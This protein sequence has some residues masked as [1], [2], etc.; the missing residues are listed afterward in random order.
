[1]IVTPESNHQNRM[2]AL[3]ATGLLAVASAIAGWFYHPLLLLAGLCPFVYWSFRRHCLQ[4]MAVMKQPFPE[5]WE[6]ILRAHVTFFSAL[7]AAE[8]ERFRQIVKVFLSEV[9]ITGI[10]TEVDDTVRVLVAASAVIPIFGFHD[11]EYHRLGEVLIYPASFGKQYE[12]K[13]Q[14]D[15]NILGMVGLK[16]LS[17]VMILS[18]PALLAGFDNPT[19]KENV[20]VHEFAHLVEQEEIEHGIPPEVPW[21]AVRQWLQYVAKEL[22]HPPGAQSHVNTYA[23]TNEHEMFAVLAE[24]FFKSPQVLE[25]KDPKLYKLLRELFHQDTRFLLS[26]TPRQR[27]RYGRNSPCPCGSGK[28]YKHCCLL[29]ENGRALVGNEATSLTSRTA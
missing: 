26:L 27:M 7:D 18:K 23:Y 25:Q 14:P 29:K 8:K 15:E 4:R 1:M 19:S 11:W 12:T 5:H 22:S 3:A 28:K 9:R 6:H 2:H 10:R 13:G 16:H 21:Q 20:G 24:Y 17:G